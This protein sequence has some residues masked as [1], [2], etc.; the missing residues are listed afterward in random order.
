MKKVLEKIH[1]NPEI[2][3]P[4]YLPSNNSDFISADNSQ[5]ASN[6]GFFNK[7]KKAESCINNF[8]SRQL[9]YQNN[10]HAAALANIE[11]KDVA[12][13]AIRSKNNQ[14]L[15]D[16]KLKNFFIAGSSESD[17]FDGENIKTGILDSQNE[18]GVNTL[19]G[20]NFKH[21]NRIGLTLSRGGNFQN[22]LFGQGSGGIAQSQA[23]IFGGY[24]RVLFGNFF[25]SVAGPQKVQNISNSNSG[26]LNAR[27]AESNLLLD[28]N[29]LA[30]VVFSGCFHKYNDNLFNG[31][32]KS[33]ITS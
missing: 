32:V 11:T 1:P 24:I 14:T 16:S 10:D 25:N 19:V 20:K 7:I 31:N 28:D 3:P 22:F 12:K 23:H 8:C 21:K 27:L 9:V 30:D 4:R 6:F 5:L 29:S 13:A 26:S 18:I 33:A 15:F 17:F 2:E